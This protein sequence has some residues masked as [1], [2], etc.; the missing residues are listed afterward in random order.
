MLDLG[1]IPQFRRF[2]PFWE[3]YL[4]GICDVARPA[5]DSHPMGS[6]SVFMAIPQAIL[7]R[8]IRHPSCGSRAVCKA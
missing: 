1:D 4:M 2:D 5:S 6:E 8:H 7:D 3:V